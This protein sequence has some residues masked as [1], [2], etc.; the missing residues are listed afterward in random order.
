MKYKMVAVSMQTDVYENSICQAEKGLDVNFPTQS[1]V[2]E[3]K[4][5]LDI[6]STKNQMFTNPRWCR[7]DVILDMKW[8]RMLL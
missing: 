2:G 6:D 4:S 8:V 3:F 1:D 7:S 5:V